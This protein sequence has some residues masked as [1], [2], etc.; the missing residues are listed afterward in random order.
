M[1]RLPAAER[2]AEVIRIMESME[3]SARDQSD[4]TAAKVAAAAGISKTRVYELVYPEFSAIRAAL[5]GPG[6]PDPMVVHLRRGLREARLEMARL[7]DLEQ[8]HKTCATRD[9]IRIV[10]ETNERLEEENRSL[11]AQIQL[12]RTR[13]Q[14]QGSR[15]LRSLPDDP[16]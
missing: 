13:G 6:M 15:T 2:R 3:V 8:I 10:V 5:P 16:A 1:K 12:L 9:E 11:R 4:F 14:G 7:R